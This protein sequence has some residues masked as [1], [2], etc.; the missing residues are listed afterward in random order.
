LDFPCTCRKDKK[1]KRSLDELK[2]ETIKVIEK[3]DQ[4]WEKVS[5][6]HLLDSA[7]KGKY[8]YY[9]ELEALLP[10][11]RGKMALM[12][13]VNKSDNILEVL[14][15]VESH[16]I[17]KVILM[18]VAEGWRVADQIAASGIPALVGPVLALP[19][20]E[21]DRY[22]RAYANA[23]LL[24]KAGVKIAIRSTEVENAR[25]LPYNAGFAGA[26]GLGKEEALRA[27][28]IEPAEIFG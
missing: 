16:G 21:Y 8:D 19:S 12:I 20:R 17:K 27:I 15:W 2:K 13:E 25:N 10:V 22:D 6:Y 26:F 28:T 18:G 23:G 7:A 5:Q 11:F 24:K 3:L 14:N 9:P 4:I 1:D